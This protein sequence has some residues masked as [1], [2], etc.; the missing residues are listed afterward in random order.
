VLGPSGGEELVVAFTKEPVGKDQRD[1]RQ[2]GEAG[3]DHHLVV[4]AGRAVVAAGDLD[5]RKHKPAFFNG[6]VGGSDF[7]HEIV[8]AH[9]EPLQVIGIV[10]DPH[11]IGV[12]VD[13]AIGDAVAGGVFIF[14]HG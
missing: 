6:G 3:L 7:S 5:D 13:D 10:A 4:V 14:A 2:V 8:P 11:L 9:L 1:R 12:T